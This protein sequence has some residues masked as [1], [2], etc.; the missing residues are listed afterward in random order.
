M[1][2]IED[3]SNISMEILLH[4]GDCRNYLKDAMG[5]LLSGQKDDIIN[6]LMVKAKNEI[7]LA[8]KAQT[9]VIQQNVASDKQNYNFL[10]SHAQDTLMT[11]MSELN[12]TKNM[13]SMYRKLEE[14]IK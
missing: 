14:K 5:A 2:D 8:H 4:A 12:M 9:N 10:F 6:E 11:I 13:I 3:L 1:E 7:I